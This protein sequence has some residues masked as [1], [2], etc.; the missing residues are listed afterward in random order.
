ML[1]WKCLILAVVD[2]LN[3]ALVTMTQL[4]IFDQNFREA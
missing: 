2:D 4:F 3:Q 1:L